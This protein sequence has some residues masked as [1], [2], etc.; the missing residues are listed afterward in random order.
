MSFFAQITLVQNH[1][2]GIEFS[3]TPGNQ[4]YFRHPHLTM[5]PHVS[6]PHLCILV[7]PIY[8]KTLQP[9]EQFSLQY[10]RSILSHWPHVF[11]APQ[12]LD[13]SFYQGVY[14]ESAFIRLSD[15]YFQS[16]RGYNELML[17]PDFYARFS[18]YEFL[19]IL[20]SD[21]IALKDDLEHW[22][23]QPYD[24]IGAPWPDGQTLTLH[25]DIFKDIPQKKLSCAV[26]NGGFSLRR[27]QKCRQLLAE[28]PETATH[29]AE[30]TIYEDLFFSLLG[31]QAHYFNIPN[32]R[33]AALFSLELRPEHYFR[34]N[35]TAPM[36]GHAWWRYNLGFWLPLLT[37][38]PPH[39]AISLL[40]KHEPKPRL[41]TRIRRLFKN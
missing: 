8:R 37:Q 6:S 33:T 29:F 11:I 26:G 12:S 2:T 27:V 28:F 35:Q 7:T 34:W 41:A 17:D 25:F 40:R 21:A 14:P 4:N 16:I 38:A 13:V 10:S 36:G 24:W 19:L 3:S 20:Q 31:T 5:C 15:H 18:D 23:H 39:E 32:E 22:C 9:L 30:N 1:P